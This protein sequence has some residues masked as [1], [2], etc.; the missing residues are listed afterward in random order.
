MSTSNPL[1]ANPN[2]PS[3]SRDRTAE[4]PQSLSGGNPEVK[5]AQGPSPKTPETRPL[6]TFIPAIPPPLRPIT[7]AVPT[8]EDLRHA[9]I[10]KVAA[11]ALEEHGL[12][13][14]EKVLAADGSGRV[15]AIRLV[16]DPDTWTDQLELL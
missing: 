11:E 10:L 5:V 6:P 12:C 13:R 7:P 8:D 1:A 15:T 9:L 16:F 14:R 2:T 3:I 4:T